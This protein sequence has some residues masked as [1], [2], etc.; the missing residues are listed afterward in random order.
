[1]I[2]SKAS[3]RPRVRSGALPDSLESTPKAHARHPP[4]SFS[5]R[6]DAL[7]LPSSHPPSLVPRTFCLLASLY[8]TPFFAFS[9]LSPPTSPLQ[10]PRSDARRLCFALFFSFFNELALTHQTVSANAFISLPSDGNIRNFLSIYLRLAGELL[11]LKEKK[12]FS[13]RISCS[14][15]CFSSFSRTT[16]F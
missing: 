12:M 10:S 15:S 16:D 14:W 1:M 7:G 11:R 4:F 8:I 9:L 3:R 6:A 13:R 5:G 2:R